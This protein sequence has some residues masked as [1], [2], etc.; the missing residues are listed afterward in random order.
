MGCKGFYGKLCH[1]GHGLPKLV[2]KMSGLE[3]VSTALRLK[4]HQ[5]SLYLR[6]KI[7]KIHSAS[8]VP[9]L[10]EK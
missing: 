2:D 1:F 9:Q 5:P 3:I 8:I 4:S 6:G 7:K 10:P